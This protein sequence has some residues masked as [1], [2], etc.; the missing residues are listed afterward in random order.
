MNTERI[1]MP[2]RA[3]WS[4]C[5]AAATL[6]LI[7]CVLPA[8]SARAEIYRWTDE[9][10]TVHFTSDLNQVPAEH[11][12]QSA[13]TL[14]RGDFIYASDNVPHSSAERIEAMKDRSR[15]LS[16]QGTSPV[17]RQ[18]ATKQAIQISDPEP[19]KYDYE[20]RKR[21]RNGRC[22]RHRRSEW[23]AWNERQTRRAAD[24]EN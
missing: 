3:R 9:R 5:C 19:R 20:C 24:Q 8:H 15:E 1:G 14:P 11:R 22:G 12:N 13:V 7:S 18:K 4:H 2:S 21:T 17:A 23:D 10:G 16:K 6:A